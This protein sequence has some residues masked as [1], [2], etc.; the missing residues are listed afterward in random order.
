MLLPLSSKEAQDVHS[1]LLLFN[2]FYKYL[3]VFMLKLMFPVVEQKQGL[4]TL[5]EARKSPLY[6]LKS[7]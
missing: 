2:Q 7:C 4:I 1:G 6:F 3:I 5:A